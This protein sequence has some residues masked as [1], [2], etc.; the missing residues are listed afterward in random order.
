MQLLIRSSRFKKRYLL[1]LKACR[2]HGAGF[3]VCGR[4]TIYGSR[5]GL[6]KLLP[7]TLSP[8]VG[9]LMMAWGPKMV[10]GD[11]RGNYYGRWVHEST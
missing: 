7:R 2:G 10:H 6:G 3:R 4:R 8:F 9:G 1:P 5:I 11:S